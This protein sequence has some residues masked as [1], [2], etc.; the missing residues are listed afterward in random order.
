[1]V[2][3]ALILL[4]AVAALA[5]FGRLRRRNGAKGG[6]NI[7]SSTTRCRSC[8]R[9]VIGKGDCPCGKGQA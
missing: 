5:M 3:G 1:M 8:G 2:K 9:P 6:M 4:I 7:L